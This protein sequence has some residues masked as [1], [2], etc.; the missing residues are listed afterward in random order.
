[1][2]HSLLA[3]VACALLATPAQAQ[4]TEAAQA[5]VEV[6]GRVIDA[7]RHGVP[8]VE[9]AVSEGEAAPAQSVRASADGAFSVR[10][11]RGRTYIFQV[12]SS[13]PW[14]PTRRVVRVPA[15]GDIEA[16]E[17]EVRLGLSEQ[18]V[19]S[20]TRNTQSIGEVAASVSV[21]SGDDFWL[22]QSAGIGDVLGRLPNVEFAGGPRSS[23]Q[24]ASVRGF[25][26]RQVTT[27]LNGA[28]M[29]T[30]RGGLIANFYM[31]PALLRSAE[32]T[33]G[34]T[35]AL[36]GT[37][38]MGGVVS[39]RTVSALD[40]L[41]PG[42]R[43]GARVTGGFANAND[44]GRGLVQAFGRT[45]NLDGLVAVSYDSW[46]PIRQGGGTFL[47]PNDG[48]ATNALVSTGWQAG[49][50]RLSFVH[51]SYLEK[52]FRSN[53][54]QADSTF[55]FKA[56]N[57][58]DQHTT[59]LTL[60]GRG[61]RATAY[62]SQMDN[63]AEPNAANAQPETL[64][65]LTT[66]GAAVQHSTSFSGPAGR[67]TVT[68]GVDV[69]RDAQVATSAGVLNTITPKGI[70]LAIGA[71][72]QDEIS[73][74]TR[75]FVTPSVRWDRFSNR[76]AD[77]ALSDTDQ[78]SASP[79]VTV[80]WAATPAF[81]LYTS[82]G[83]AFR[84][85]S[86]S[87]LYQFSFI[88]TNFANFNPNPDLKPE[89]SMQYEGGVSWDVRG[90]FGSN[91]RFTARGS[92]FGSRDSDLIASTT[93]GTF[94]HPVL[95]NR[96]ILQFQNVANASRPGAEL[97]AVYAAGGTDVAV[98]YSVI[99]VT[100]RS[101][102]N[103]LYSPPDK[104]VVTLGHTIGRLGTRLAWTTTAARAQDYDATV[105]RRR[106]G[107][108]VH[109]LLST[110]APGSGRIRVDAGIT[111]LFDKRYAAYKFNGTFTNVPEVGR[112]ATVRATVVW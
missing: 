76:P 12:T 70:Q 35:S 29:N 1:M 27:L 65:G 105:A 37:G 100:D 44:D 96:P 71:F 4:P 63:L 17:I 86:L 45:G 55:P 108:V 69:F 99:R 87:E 60:E 16:V 23:G 8:D 75:W 11:T 59:T 3:M 102:G 61:I 32:V 78:N 33:R 103:G 56:M 24:V 40:L 25:T 5:D 13:G 62:R 28:R 89:R 57:H 42:R 7:S 50:R 26:G 47:T 107:Y 110:W 34:S 95:G 49:E 80:A 112:N 92:V 77:A 68:Y 14:A 64:T 30:D 52:N 10:L 83:R 101:T 94:R 97:T 20:A 82:V 41:E 90:I 106:A 98:N 104:G 46:G 6:V 54:P 39:F 72:V 18:V 2:V 66:W 67:H 79:K 81:R 36:Y 88:L 91:D 74:G 51:H 58:L 93:V 48:H 22:R 53:N 31:D 9:V 111:N 38:G 21:A 19:V 109:D 84:A 85:P 15:R 73:L 43:A